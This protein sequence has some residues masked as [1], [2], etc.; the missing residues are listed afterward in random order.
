MISDSGQLAYELHAA[1]ARLDRAADRIL[2]R[3]HGIS[4]RRF[5][6]LFMLA[7]HGASSQR[8]LAEYLNV[9]EASMSRMALVLRD[10]G[11]LE[12]R[13]DPDGGNRRRLAL[14]PEGAA[15]VR[16]AKQLLAARLETIV[17][18]ADIPAAAYLGYTRA[19][20]RAL[21]DADARADATSTAVIA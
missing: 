6:P 16:H 21:V 13:A 7:E 15:L 19:L 1:V 12:I 3:E 14:T 11:K 8:N 9:S 10:S 2:R 5:L 20:S 18:H 17:E 4:Y